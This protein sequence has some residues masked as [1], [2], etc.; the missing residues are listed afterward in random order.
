MDRD[1]ER[2][3]PEAKASGAPE[4]PIVLVTG[5]AGAVGSALVRALEAEHTVIGLDLAGKQAACELFAVDLTSEASVTLALRDIRARHGPRLASV[6]HLAAYFDF[7]GEDSPLY[8]AVNVDGTRNLLRGLRELQ[9]EQFVY[10]GTMLVHRPGRPGQP[11]T[12]RTAIDPRWAYPR[13]K[14]RAEEAIRAERGS[15]PCVLLHLAGLYDERTVVPTLAEQIRRIYERD[16]EA[17]AYSGA[18]ETGQSFLHREDMVDAFVR[19]V[20]RC[21]ALGEETTILVGEPEAVGYGELQARLARLIHGESDWTTIAVPKPFARAGAWLMAKSEPLVPDDLDQ[22]EPPFI[23]PFMVRMADDHYELDISQ[24]RAL[25]GWEPRHTIADALPR[26]V[27]TLRADPLGWYR[28]NGLTPPHW[29]TAAAARVDD[30]DGLRRRAEDAYR[31]A[32]RRFLWA[33][34][35]VV[36]AGIWLLSSPPILGYRS[37]AMTWS[38]VACGALIVI[39][40]L[41]SL[42]WRFGWIRWVVAALGLWAM[43]APLLF[44]APTAAAYL[45]GTLVGALVFGFAVLA[46]P[47]PGVGRVAAATGPVVPPGWDYSPSSWSQR[48]PIIVLAVVGLLISRY[49]AAYQLGHIEG[50]WDPLFAGDPTDPRNGTEE[51]I[52]SSVSRAWPVPD[53]GAGALVYML[54]ILTGIV[55]S[56]RRWRTMPWLVVL[57]GFMIVPLGLVSLTFIIIQ[58]ILLGTWCTLCLVAAAAM[59][60]QVPY[61]LDELVATG[62]FL[63]RRK[64]QGR[65]LLRIFLMGDTDEG[66]DEPIADEF[67]RS[68]AAVVRDMA[69]GGVGLPWTLLASIAIGVWLMLTRL[70]LDASGAMA[71]ADHLIGALVITVSVTALA[72]TAR[73]ARFLNMLLG[74]ALTITATVLAAGAAQAVAGM[75]CGVALIA[76]SVPR[77]SIGHRYGDWSR[78]LL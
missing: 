33:P 23:R 13:S 62:Q 25:L 56:A 61:S 18:L 67:E 6:I 78:R 71:N 31:D 16:A 54:E 12:E 30:P 19:T 9:V 72:E 38:D 49:L 48:M 53:A 46:R 58:P 55:G 8:E 34:F 4:R 59:L 69:R 43:S 47:E 44:W 3:G 60:V 24:A 15:I 17:H 73:P 74:F 20:A 21:G 35:L 64:R 26:I 40:G 37:M 77:G 29:L 42:S 11:I 66:P 1:A 76:L 52:T 27:E 45:N 41:V 2:A 22:G 51:I 39:A 70:T 63:I 65:P 57:F 7:T 28:A 75:V 32:H 36:A 50:V 68:P 14:A 5:A 10:A